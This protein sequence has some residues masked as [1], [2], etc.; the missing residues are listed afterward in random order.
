MTM[1]YNLP[2]LYLFIIGNYYTSVHAFSNT[3]S[4]NKTV[5]PRIEYWCYIT[6]LIYKSNIY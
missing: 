5:I 6:L 3:L 2:V 1:Y 4:V